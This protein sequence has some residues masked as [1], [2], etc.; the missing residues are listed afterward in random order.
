MPNKKERC[1]VIGPI[2]E[3]NSV[4]RRHADLLLHEIIEPVLAAEPFN[5]DV[6]RADKAD[7]PGMVLDQIVNSVLDAGVI[8]ADLTFRNSNVFW[9]LGL[10][11]AASQ[12]VLHIAATGT[13]IPF[14]VHGHRVTFVDLGDWQSKEEARASLK[15]FATAMG[16][17]D[18]QVTNPV[19]QARRTIQLRQSGDP[20]EQALADMTERLEQLERLL[21]RL[22]KPREPFSDFRNKLIYLA[23]GQERREKSLLETLADQEAE[24]HQ[25]LL[26]ERLMDGPLTRELRNAAEELD[27]ELSDKDRN[28]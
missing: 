11:H 9:E 4:E 12:K 1:F 13:D 3:P 7:N 15:E 25:K 17:P 16:Q 21:K 26:A 6:R 22:P 18:Y 28:E 20:K 24:A 2:G 23:G 14:D 19:T 27:R 5:F 10:A 8:V